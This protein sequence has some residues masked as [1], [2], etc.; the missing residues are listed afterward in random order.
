MAPE[1]PVAPKIPGRLRRIMGLVALGAWFGGVCGTATGW[2]GAIFWP[3][4]AIDSIMYGLFGGVCGG[5]LGMLLV[6]AAG[7]QK[8][9]H[10]DQM[11]S[12]A[13]SGAFGTAL[14]GIGG[15]AFLDMLQAVTGRRA[16]D[17][18]NLAED[19][20][21][22]LVIA[23]GTGAVVTWGVSHLSHNEQRLQYAVL[24]MF[25]TSAACCF[26]IPATIPFAVGGAAGGLLSQRSL[27][28]R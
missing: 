3:V 18:S 20:M 16:G 17:L 28:A 13:F 10:L 4:D 9:R 8:C 21:I 1:T 22:M 26:V 24:G 15:I 6:G 2:V 23:A 25:L 14:G 19:V 12:S 7:A 5:S 27:V 11:K